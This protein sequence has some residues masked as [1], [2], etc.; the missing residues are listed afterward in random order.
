MISGI[1]PVSIGIYQEQNQQLITVLAVTLFDQFSSR[2]RVPVAYCVCVCV[3]VFSLDR[4]G[5][6]VVA[7]KALAEV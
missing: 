3:C 4:E 7:S 1:L 2:Q 5:S 6:R